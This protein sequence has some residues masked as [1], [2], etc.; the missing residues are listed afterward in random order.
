MPRFTAHGQ[1][2]TSL[3]ID[4]NTMKGVIDEEGRQVHIPAPF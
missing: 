3:A 1:N 4:G 2:D